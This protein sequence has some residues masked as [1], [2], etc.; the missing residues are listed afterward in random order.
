MMVGSRGDDPFLLG[1]DKFSTP[2][3]LFSTSRHYTPPNGK[4]ITY[5]HPNGKFG[6]NHRLKTYAWE[7]KGYVNLKE[8]S[9]S[10]YLQGLIHPWWLGMGF[11]RY[12]QGFFNI[13]P[14]ETDDTLSSQA[15]KFH[16]I[17]PFRPCQPTAVHTLRFFR[18]QMWDR[19][20]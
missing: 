18:L 13:P 5:P 20:E 2:C 11:S 4:R 9:L 14:W 8:G 19:A 17:R 7:K 16:P 12:L 1:P 6:T 3:E 15:W 10:R